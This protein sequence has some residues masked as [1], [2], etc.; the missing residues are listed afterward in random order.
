MYIWWN[1]I[2]ILSIA[3][4]ILNVIDM[5]ALYHIRFFD[6][7]CGMFCINT[8][9]VF[10]TRSDVKLKIWLWILHCVL[11][12]WSQLTFVKKQIVWIHLKILHLWTEAW[13]GNTN[14]SNRC[15][16]SLQAR[17]GAKTDCFQIAYKSWTEKEQLTPFPQKNNEEGQEPIWA[18]EKT[19]RRKIAPYWRHW[20]RGER[21]S[22]CSI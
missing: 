13:A 5:K 14:G 21:W 16:N 9:D 20:N 8:F 1:A 12:D 6:S 15:P 10:L 19:R 2:M 4:V 3:S 11:A 17:K 7:W 22:R 18:P